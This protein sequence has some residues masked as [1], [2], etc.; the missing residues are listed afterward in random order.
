MKP[1]SVKTGCDCDSE[2]RVR[3]FDLFYELI[4]CKKCGVEWLKLKDDRP[5]KA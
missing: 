5:G 3:N 1:K 2:K 4:T